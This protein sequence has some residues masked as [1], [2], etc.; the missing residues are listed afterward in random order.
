MHIGL[1]LKK[2]F[3]AWVAY[4]RTKA[5]YEDRL[6]NISASFARRCFISR[7]L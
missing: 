6:Q 5:E 7:P 4:D 3:G 1:G 2:L